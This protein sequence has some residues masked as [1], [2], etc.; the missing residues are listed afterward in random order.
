MLFEGGVDVE[1]PVV[2]VDTVLRDIRGVATSGTTVTKCHLKTGA[3][4]EEKRAGVLLGWS[5]SAYSS[6][7]QVMC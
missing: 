7:P 2:Q 6:P 3:N 4:G 1:L 5:A